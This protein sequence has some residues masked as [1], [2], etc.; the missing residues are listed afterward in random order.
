MPYL[1]NEPATA[2]TSTTKDTFSG[3]ASTTDFTLSRAATQNAIRV[4]VENVVQDP[5]VAYTCSGTTLSFTSAPPTGTS[6]IY[7]VHL[8]PPA[9]TVAPPTTINNNTTFTGGVSLKNE[10]PEDTDGGRESKVTF[11]GLQSGE[12]E[13]TLAEIQASHDGTADDQKGD[14][15]FKTN[16]GSD[17]AAPTEAARI[18]SKS[19]FLIGHSDNIDVAGHEAGLQVVGQGTADYHGATVSIVGNA[20]NSN[21]AY[22]NFA[23]GRS[24]TAG[25]ATAAVADDTVGQ[26]NF[27]AADGTDFANRVAN[28]TAQVNGGVG[29][30]DTPGRLVFATTSDGAGDVTTRLRI[31]EH[32]IK[33]GS[34]TAE[35]N[36]L[37][38]YEQGTFSGRL[39]S[40][41]TGS[42][43]H[44]TA[45]T[46]GYY[47][48]IGRLVHW[49]I[50]HTEQASGGSSTQ[51]VYFTGLPFTTAYYGALSH[52]FYSGFSNMGTGQ[53]PIPRYQQNTD[54]I[55]FQKFK[56]GA[57]SEIQYQHFGGTMNL[58]LTGTYYTTS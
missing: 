7:V 22:L 33:F 45:A 48:K 24:N 40:G 52:W 43:T 29:N 54:A 5:G 4:V 15:I 44:F 10:T 35:A 2:F 25:T 49:Q 58:M 50:H 55:V 51:S 18:D 17:N 38:D 14:L 13:S 19:N 8:G 21:G 28:I 56:D 30:N 16:D 1:G 34:D 53:V 26:I 36:G 57:G 20:N 47:V 41:Y 27:S 11:K 12:E 39:S 9:A 42:V 46:T 31:D 37:N 32:G 3:D 6:N 23:K